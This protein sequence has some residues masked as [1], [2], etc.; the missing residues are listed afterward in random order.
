[1]NDYPLLECR[2]CINKEGCKLIT[3]INKFTEENSF[4]DISGSSCDEYTTSHVI[5][6]NWMAYTGNDES[7]EEEELDYVPTTED[8]FETLEDGLEDCLARGF[9]AKGVYMSY[10]TMQLFLEDDFKGTSIKNLVSKEHGHIKVNRDDSIPIGH[11]ALAL[12]LS[13]EDEDEEDDDN[14]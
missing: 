2:D 7:I 13:D 9:T 1:M 8:M 3:K 6:D 11:F 14:I 10:A 12:T 4:L 5:D